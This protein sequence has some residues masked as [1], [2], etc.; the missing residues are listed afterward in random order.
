[1]LDALQRLDSEWFI[2]INHT[3]NGF[4]DVVMPIFT[5]RWIWIPLYIFMAYALFRQ[6]GSRTIVIGLTIAIM[7]LVSDQGANLFKNT[8][9]KRPRPCQNTELL[10]NN[11]I[12]TPDGCGG[13]YGYFSGH[14]ANCFAISI[15]VCLLMRRRN[16]DRWKTWLLLF[17]WALMVIWSRVYMGV[18]YPGDV[19]SGAVFGLI[20]GSIT[21]YCL[22]KFYLAPRNA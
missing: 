1:M 6:Y 21:Y 20:V 5:N 11:T 10:E 18:H 7:I 12:F 15:L 16:M 19:L 4:L 9:V 13:P 17:V 14:A 22:S 3:R 2:A 8:I